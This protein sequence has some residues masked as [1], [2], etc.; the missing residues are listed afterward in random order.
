M[1]TMFKAAALALAS[2]SAVAI[3]PMVQAQAV[4]AGIGTASLDDAVARS[5]AAVLANNQI[6]LTYKAQIDAA[7]AKANAYNSEL[8]GMRTALE[9]AAKQPNANQAALQQQAKAYQ[10][11]QAYAQQDIGNMTRNVQLATEYSRSQIVAKLDQ[12]VKQAMAKRGVRVLLKPDAL[13]ITTDQSIDITTDVINELNTVVPSVSIDVPAGWP[14]N[15][16]AAAAP[17]AAPAPTKKPS[18]R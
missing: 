1:K 16:A 6:N 18:G 14:N 9:T 11:R 3:V 7:Q 5:N 10:D 13:I 4:Q 15:Q 2:V 12:A 8:A 17:A